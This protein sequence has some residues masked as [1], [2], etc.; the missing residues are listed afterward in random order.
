[1]FYNTQNA[2][3]I[4]I[5]EVAQ[6]VVKD[7]VGGSVIKGKCNN[8]NHP[9]GQDTNYGNLEINTKKNKVTCY[10][11][12]ESWGPIALY[13][14][15]TNRDLVKDFVE[16]CSELHTYFP[17]YIYPESNN[18][19]IDFSK[20]LT[21]QELTFLG[22]STNYKVGSKTYNIRDFQNK[23]P[24][25]YDY[26]LIS[27]SLLKLKKIEDYFMK[28]KPAFPNHNS[29]M[30]KQK[31]ELD[32]KVFNILN[33]GIKSLKEFKVSSIQDVQRYEKYLSNLI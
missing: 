7:F 19:Y 32:E 28:L 24:E 8:I 1:M 17:Q 9:G 13:A 2:N 21:N 33:K 30:I 20:N 26:L 12:G 25:E 5:E 4:P 23:F 3:N 11:C 16:C 31:N 18:T 22:I 27:K 15:F 6:L 29:E 10:A 14:A